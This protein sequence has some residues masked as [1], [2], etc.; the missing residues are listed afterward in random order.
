[1]KKVTIKVQNGCDR[2]NMVVAL[3]NARYSV[4]TKKVR[5]DEPY[6]GAHDYYVCFEVDNKEIT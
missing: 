6:Y 3:A 5:T 4:Q 2:D 1:M